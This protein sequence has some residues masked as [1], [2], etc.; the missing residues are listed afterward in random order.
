ML[1]EGGLR[2][3]WLAGGEAFVAACTLRDLVCEAGWWGLLGEQNRVV[4]F[5]RWCGRWRRETGVLQPVRGV[6][7][8]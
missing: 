4:C 6:G 5:E 7:C 2:R 3:G 1:C 8:Y